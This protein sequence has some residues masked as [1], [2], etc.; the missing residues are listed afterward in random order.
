MLAVSALGG[1][2]VSTLST[3]LFEA[4]ILLVLSGVAAGTLLD[5]LALKKAHARPN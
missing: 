1:L 3:T 4:G 2:T 5:F